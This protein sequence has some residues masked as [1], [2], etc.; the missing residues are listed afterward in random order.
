MRR[1]MQAGLGRLA[2]VAVCATG[3]GGCLHPGSVQRA[4]D[5]DVVEGRYI[6]PEAYAAYLRGAIA[7]A[8]GH[9]A[10]AVAAYEEAARRDPASPEPWTRIAELRCAADARGQAGPAERAIAHALDLDPGYARAWAAR[11]T[12]AEAR[13][14]SAARRAAAARASELDPDGDAANVLLAA[15]QPSTE[16][17]RAALV[18]LTVTAREPPIAW[19]ALATWA[20]AHGDVALWTRALIE[21]ARVAP[22]RRQSVARSAEE[23]AGAGNVAEARAVAAAA[24]DAGEAPWPERLALAARLAVDESIARRDASSVRRR[25]TRG[26]VALDEAAGRAWLAGERG[27]A[28]D[29]VATDTG[30]DPGA[31]GARLVLAVAQGVDLASAGTVRPGDVP[32]S[33]A[34]IVAFGIAV[35]HAGASAET[36]AAVARAPRAP[37]VAGDD[38]VTRPAVDLVSRGA[39]PAGAL[40]PDGLVELAGVEGVAPGV[41]LDPE[42]ARLDLRHRLLAHALVQPDGPRVQQ[43][44]GRLRSVSAFDP[45]VASAFALLQLASGAPVS[46]DAPRT[47][48]MRNPADPLLAA[49]ALRLA[50]KV[51]D[52]EVARRARETLSALGKPR[53]TVD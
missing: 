30:A 7:G 4:Y 53:L 19:D 47:L 34:A 18:A 31:L 33:P 37:F 41:R 28:R 16:P 39:L 32:A 46:P 50:E 20:Q 21:L 43:L 5:G 52:Q 45:V 44:A 14:D 1:A 15:S 38:R 48:L 12:C 29:L 2:A 40:P 9:T 49:T 26:R 23:L 24:L 42:D 36:R 17:T 10:D 6:S 22:E 25:A 11:A 35:V 13:G 51:G 27:L 3:L 8:E